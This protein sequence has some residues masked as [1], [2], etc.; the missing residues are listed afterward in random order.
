MIARVDRTVI[1]WAALAAL[2]IQA[3]PALAADPARAPK[4]Q[5]LQTLVLE[6]SRQDMIAGRLAELIA[7]FD[8]L[9]QDLESNGEIASA[10]AAGVAQLVGRLEE[11]RTGH[12]LRVRGLLRLALRE[13]E[14]YRSHLHQARR[15]VRLVT[16]QLGSLLLQAGMSHA[17]EV[18]ADEVRAVIGV[19][20]DL[21][22][23][24]MLLAASPVDANATVG[25]EIVAEQQFAADRLER[26]LEEVDSLGSFVD[27]AMAAVR[28]SRASRLLLDKKASEL[29]TTAA[30]RVQ[31]GQ[32]GQ[33]I[34]SQSAALDAL[35]SAERM[36]RPDA[37]LL[38]LVR[39]RNRLGQM[40]SDQQAVRRRSEGVSAEAF[41]QVGPTLVGAQ[42]QVEL[43][44]PPI[45]EAVD[46]GEH[47]DAI[48]VA[49]GASLG[50]LEAGKRS[51]ALA[52]QRQAE[53]AIQG[54]LSDVATRIAAL[55][56]LDEAYRQLQAATGRLKLLQDLYDRQSQLLRESE[57]LVAEGK[58]V[59]HLAAAQ[60]SLGDEV[61]YVQRTLRSDEKW[62]KIISRPLDVAE[63]HMRK[64][65]PLLA[66]GEVSEAQGEAL[67]A[68]RKLGEAVDAADKQVA[69]LEQ[70]WSLKQLASDMRVVGEHVAALGDEQADLRAETERAAGGETMA[71]DLPVRQETAARA[72]GEVQQLTSSLGQAREVEELIRQAETSMARAGESL[73]DGKAMSAIPSQ[74]NAEGYLKRAGQQ[75]VQVA[76]KAKYLQTVIGS[77]DQM[78]AQAM[79]L[80]QRQI[81]LRRATEKAKLER[82]GELA[83]EQDVLH[84]ELQEWVKWLGQDYAAEHF[85]AAD[86]AMA[87]ALMG[88]R[89]HKR[90]G[91]VAE[92]KRAEEALRK[93]IRE[94]TRLLLSMLEMMEEPEAT[95]EAMEF[96]ALPDYITIIL[97][98]A[99]EQKELRGEIAVAAET[100]LPTFMDKQVSIRN[101]TDELLPVFEEINITYWPL[102]S[103]LVHMDKATSALQRKDRAEAED[104]MR[105]AEKDLRRAFAQLVMLAYVIVLEPEEEEEYDEEYAEEEEEEEQLQLVIDSM[106]DWSTYLKTDPGGAPP[107]KS[108]SEWEELLQRE[109][110]ALNENFAR[111]LPL[112]YR[113]ML[114]QY[115]E[116]L[117]RE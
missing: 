84:G 109:R 31:S 77:M 113:E 68:M 54:A 99:I 69:L 49:A 7:R 112:E 37:T 59:G 58:E 11:I 79:D 81:A 98:L 34:A 104:R 9:R 86:I 63:E 33:A 19:E 21:R 97:M 3:G 43:A 91:A 29:L 14:N 67:G 46:L 65:R 35:R 89:Q 70:L 41:G 39:A 102:K 62:S 16:R 47:A 76:R 80:L 56:E 48:R 42:R 2:A 53:E 55:Q 72:A 96:E 44:L 50:A 24:A 114:K 85:E 6:A 111:E 94:M 45:D 18:F 51:D 22:R 74:A 20:E 78:T 57:L 27:D 15:E 61:G 103:A 13:P 32:L 4:P 36:L 101:R 108:R 71:A 38:A 28:I 87:G 5:V 66:S 75:A 110:E 90:D 8:G 73:T 30:A 83:G 17:A 60:K 88:L 95:N 105:K 106:T 117:S 100:A 10:P 26:L 1:V 92:Q 64:A 23:R 115:Y 25:E 12:L 40:L 93:A 107:A 116:A 52:A 82:F